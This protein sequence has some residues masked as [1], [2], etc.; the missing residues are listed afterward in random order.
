MI[1]GIIGAGKLG[2][3]LAQLSLRA[4]YDVCI[5]GSS[6]PEK[7]RLIIEV[8]APGAAVMTT[9]EVAR[10]ADVVMLALPLSKFRQL[11]QKQLAGKC[12][13][14]ATNYWWEVDGLRDDILPSSQSSSEAIQEFLAHSRVVKGLSH[15]SY[16]DLY[17]EAK[18]AGIPDRK[19]I[20]I[21]GDDARDV[22]V[23]AQIIDKLGFDAV[24]IGRLAE[25]RYLEPGSPAFGANVP[26]KEL[27]QL[28][29]QKHI[30]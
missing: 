21:A 23:V 28:L 13:I 19:A 1:I 22:E 2:T 14:D 15:M 26:A 8:L 11:P 5:S 6:E 10:H 30:A 7:I 4:G 3:V 16:H 17:D 24:R 9:E 18:L 27:R 20:A 25:G 29:G 12:V